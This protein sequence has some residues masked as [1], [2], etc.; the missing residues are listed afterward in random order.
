MD[1][2]PKSSVLALVINPTTLPPPAYDPATLHDAY[3]AVS[4]LRPYRSFNIMPGNAGAQIMNDPED[5][6]VI[7]PLLVQLQIRIGSDGVAAEDAKR[8]LIDVVS[9]ATSSLGMESFLQCAIKVVAHG[10][11]PEGDARGWLRDRFPENARASRLGPDFFEAGLRYR[12]IV[13]NR[14][15]VLSVEPFVRDNAFVFVD[16]DVARVFPIAKSDLDLDIWVDEA[17]AFMDRS[18]VELL[19]S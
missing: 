16:Y 18:V 3:R 6:L 5:A 2:A 13:E 4:A 12:K 8:Q 11:A 17:F 10:D 7:Q 14:E 1:L 9:T 19:A 15:E